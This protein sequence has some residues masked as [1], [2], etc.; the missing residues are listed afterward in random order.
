MREV[1]DRV[2]R[3]GADAWFALD[4]AELLGAEAARLRQGHRH[5]RCLVRFRRH[6]RSACSPQRPEE[7]LHKPADLYLEGSDQHRGWFQSSL[8]TG[9]A[10][11]GAAP[12]RQVLTHGFTVDAHGRKMSKSI[13]NVVEPQ[14]VIDS[15]GAD[16]LRLWMAC[17]RLP[18]R[19][20]GVRRDPQAQR[21][22]LSPHPQ[23][24]AFPAGQPG[25]LRSGHRIWLPVEDM[26]L[27]DQW[28]MA[29]AR[30]L[31]ES[32]AEAYARLRL[33]RVVQPLQNFCS[34]DLGA[35]YLDV[36]KD[37]LYTMPD[38]S[39]G[40]R[41]A[42]SAMYRISEAFV[43]WIAPVLSFTADEIW[44]YLPGDRARRTCCSR[45]SPIST[46]CC[47]PD[48]DYRRPTDR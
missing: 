37:R 29:R 17:R 38:D 40:R 44:R 42:Q 14:K 30:E 11:D 18:Q 47:L 24:R 15:L 36:T 31:H 35:L 5:P 33:R 20:V 48:G 45:P 10:M 22:C 4:A 39:R 34:N 7:G 12:Y 6:P 28:A 8:L 27:L 32:I 16:V 46:S 19:D 43:R 9:M 26:P 41:S 23:H 1:A 2:E 13:G 25:R 21:R 3:D